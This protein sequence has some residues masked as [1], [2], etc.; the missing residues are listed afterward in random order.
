MESM[1]DGTARTLYVFDFG[2]HRGL[3]LENVPV[4]YIVNSC[5]PT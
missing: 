1:N 3:P 2:K 5:G 4:D